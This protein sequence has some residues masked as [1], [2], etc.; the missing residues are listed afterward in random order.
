MHQAPR[1]K[2]PQY[3]IRDRWLSA[4][5]QFSQASLRAQQASSYVAVRN[6]GRHRLFDQ[7]LMTLS[8]PMAAKKLLAAPWVA[9]RR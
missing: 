9:G 1:P 3:E 8:G 7:P 2:R 4:L 5:T 6:R